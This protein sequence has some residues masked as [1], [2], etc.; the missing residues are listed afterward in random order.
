MPRANVVSTVGQS[1]SSRLVVSM[2]CTERVPSVRCQSPSTTASATAKAT[3]DTAY[4]TPR[5]TCAT[6]AATVP[7]TLTM[8]TAVQ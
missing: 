4:G 6:S 7:K 3:V 5:P 8:A 1:K 2:L